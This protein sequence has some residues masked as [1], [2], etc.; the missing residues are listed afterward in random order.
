MV[1]PVKFTLEGKSILIHTLDISPSG[2]RIAGL[3]EEVRA[4]QTIVLSRGTQKAH[5]RIVWVQ[6]QGK[7]E[8]QAGLEGVDLKDKFWGIE[9]E[10]DDAVDKDMDMLMKLLK[11][12]QKK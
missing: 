10:K 8:F 12:S 1:L 4:G 11:G 9:L 7:G 6:A 3:H 2:A 5:F